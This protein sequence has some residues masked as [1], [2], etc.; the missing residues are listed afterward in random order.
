MDRLVILAP[1]WLGDAVMAL[2]AIADVRRAAP[3]AT[4]AVAARPVIAPLFRLVPGV[5]ETIVL[6]ARLS[7]A[8]RAPSSRASRGTTCKFGPFFAGGTGLFGA[9]AHFSGTLLERSAS[10]VN[11]ARWHELGV[12]IGGKGF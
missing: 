8:S 1:N 7:K 3:A 11:V 4:I 2:P 5:N 6:G 9:C 12:E 10:I